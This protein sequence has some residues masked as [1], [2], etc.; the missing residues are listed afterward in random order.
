M[1]D[2]APRCLFCGASLPAVALGRG[3]AP[4]PA[5]PSGPEPPEATPLGPFDRVRPLDA[6][7]R[8]WLS[9]TPEGGGRVAVVKALGAADGQAASLW[10]ALPPHPSVVRA[11]GLLAGEDGPRVVFEYVAPDAHSRKVQGRSAF[12]RRLRRDSLAFPDVLRLCVLVCRGLEHAYAGGLRGHGNLKPS[13]L[14]LGLDGGLRVS[15]PGLAGIESPLELAPERFDGA[16]ADERS[17]VYSLGVLLFQMTSGR[18]PFDT[19]AG[20][21][22]VTARYREDLRHLHQDALV[23][24]L[25]SPLAAVLERCLQKAPSAR[26]P[27]VA[28]LR[29]EL[30]DLL[31]RETGLLPALPP[32]GEA[33]GW[34]R[35]QQAL[36]LLAVG[37]AEPAVRAFDEALLVL[38]PTASVRAVRATALNVLGQ[39]EEAVLAAE[40]AIAIDP[41]YAPAWRQKGESLA[42]LGRHEEALDALEQTAVIAPRDASSLVALGRLLGTVGRLPQ[43]L[44]AYDRAVAADAEHVDVWLERGSTL[45]AAGLRADAAGAFLRFLD[46]APTGHP[47]RRRAEDLLRD[48]REI[49]GAAAPPPSREQPTPAEPPPSF[50]APEEAGPEPTDVASLNERGVAMFRAGRLDLALLA[51]DRAL[52]LDSRRAATWSN[53]ANVLF[54]L[55]R[56]Q[57][58]LADQE[59]ALAREPRAPG[60]WLS[61]ATIERALGRPAEARRSLL[62]LLSLQPP[63]DSRLLDQAR[64]LLAEIEGQGIPPAPETSL[65]FLRAGVQHAEAGRL[66][67]AVAD[68]DQALHRDLLLTTAWLFK[69]DA[70]L[71][72]G[73]CVE[74]ARA[75]DE[76]LA[77]DPGEVRLLLGLGRARARLGDLEVATAVLT[78]ALDLAD[79]E[80]RPQVERLLKAVATRRAMAPVPEAVPAPVEVAPAVEEPSVLHP[81]P[82]AGSDEPPAEKAPARGATDWAHEGEAALKAGRLEDA[83]SAFGEALQHSPRLRDGWIGRGLA[84]KRLGRLDEAVSSFVKVLQADPTDPE[85]LYEK[86]GSEEQ[87]GRSAEAARSYEQ[88][89]A[90]A[91]GDPRHERARAE[92]AKLV[93]S[94]Q[95]PLIPPRAPVD[96]VV[97]AAAQAAQGLHAEA[98]DSLDQAFAAGTDDAPFWMARGDSLRALGRK[99]E[100]AAAFDQAIKR[101]P[102]DPMAW[103][104]KGD[105]LDAA[106]LFGEAVASYDQAVELHPRH[107]GAWN[108][109]GVCLTRLDRIEEALHCFTRALELDPRFALARFNKGAAEDRLGRGEEASR[110]YQA[111]LSLAPPTLRAQI[112]YAQKRLQAL[113]APRA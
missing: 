105:A 88:F 77:A 72:L 73:R 11:A 32:P 66:E 18:P 24:R 97:A 61:K 81:A 111:F 43:A 95:V 106:G 52:G 8:T 65:G 92:L 38:P 94:L 75:Y 25:D 7:G 47:A 44:S 58:G 53:R 54:R 49:A 63:P 99:E 6:S 26:F 68:F 13:N 82:S 98:L 93:G 57:E 27:A 23:P 104:K 67:P 48:V 15:E 71:A 80:S 78:H 30:E 87:A 28:A 102:R 51:F 59:K 45:A 64:S 10:T 42:A 1:S 2:R 41:Q 22:D 55:G 17:D 83:L 103:I 62:D 69:G 76:G 20:G 50:V 4:S 101:D 90:A 110:S 33:A 37:R 34:E 29:T 3:P 86:A 35:A 31:R 56:P 14:L 60:S 84:L 40:Q 9:F 12:E 36:A 74:A 112:Q 5:P 108:S 70:L 100:A 79:D 19:P 91:P 16:A 109:K 46:V 96:P 89:L 39:R 107:L 85:A 113:K 21:G